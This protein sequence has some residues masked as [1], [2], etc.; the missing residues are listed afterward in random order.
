VESQA[1]PQ[2]YEQLGETKLT[3]LDVIAQAVG[4]MGPVFGAILLL[5]TVVGAN[6]AGKGAGLASPVAI[7]VAAIGIAAVGWIIAQ[8]ARRIHAAGALYDY[9]SAGFGEKIGS[10]FGWIYLGGLLVLS[11]AIPLLIGGQIQDFLKSAY[12]IGIPYWVAGLG[13]TVVLFA[14][15]YFGIKISTRIQLALVLFSASIVTVFLIYVITQAPKLSAEPFNPGSAHGVGNFFFGVLY[16]ILLFVGFESSANLAEETSNPKK[17][18]P[19]AVLLSVG[20][21]LV[22][23][24]VASYSQAVGFGLDAKAWA[25]SGAPVLVLALPKAAGG[26]GASWL[27]DLMYILLILDL[28]AVGIGASVAATRLLF[29]LARDRRVPGVFAKVS[30]RYG[31]PWVAIV[32]VIVLTV[33]EILWVRLSKGILPLNGAPEYFPFFLWLAQYGSLSLAVLYAAVSLAGLIG[34]WGKVNPAPLVVAF[35]VGIAITGLAIFSAVYKV[36]SP[37]NT[38]TLYWAIWAGIGIVITL[39]LIGTGRFR[40]SASGAGALTSHLEAEEQVHPEF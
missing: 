40:Q 17:Y 35:I 5:I 26:Y 6:N 29:S 2:K 34:L 12:N 36:P 25:A 13:F 14:V 18:I 37:L 9:I 38:V 33:A 21:V 30:P 28:A 11:I 1:P 10:V 23:F 31:T 32:T 15:L 16:A 3:F 7:I 27:F 4:F 24:V 8:F 19:R 20:I 39:V 22:Y